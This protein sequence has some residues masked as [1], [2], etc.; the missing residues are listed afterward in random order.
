MSKW[1]FSDTKILVVQLT[2][3]INEDFLKIVN[4]IHIYLKSSETFEGC[5]ITSESCEVLEF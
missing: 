3:Q 4:S 5:G 1:V 2:F